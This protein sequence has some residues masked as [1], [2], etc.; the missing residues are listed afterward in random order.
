MHAVGV[1][2]GIDSITAIKQ[3]RVFGDWNHAVDRGGTVYSVPDATVDGS[4][5]RNG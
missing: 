3:L 4:R 5:S 1:V 2:C